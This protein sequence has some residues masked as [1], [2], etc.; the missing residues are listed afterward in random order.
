[1]VSRLTKFNK[2][3]L[4]KAFDQLL[5]PRTPQEMFMSRKLSF[6]QKGET[7]FEYEIPRIPTSI[8]EGAEFH[9]TTED[10]KVKDDL[11]TSLDRVG[12]LSLVTEYSPASATEIIASGTLENIGRSMKTVD[13]GWTDWF[14]EVLH[15]EGDVVYLIPDTNLIS[16]HYCSNVLLPLLG[17]E[18]F[19]QLKFR[20]PRLVVLEVESRCNRSK[21]GTK[22]KRL[23]FYAAKEILFLKR[24]HA[25]LLPQLNIS[26]LEG[27]SRI[28]GSQPR[29]TDAW[30]RR[31]IHDFM[32][33]E[34]KRRRQISVEG[35]RD[36]SFGVIFL[37]CD[38]MNALAASAEDIP[39]L[40]FS[41]IR[42]GKIS[43]RDHSQLVELIIDTAI[44]FG[45]IKMKLTQANKHKVS[46]LIKGIW[47]PKTPIDWETD[48]VEIMEIENED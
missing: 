3:K 26:L 42:N 43:F 23:A 5:T 34:I 40:Y 29:F 12:A 33:E 2:A 44:T 31:E 14:M 4:S 27:F 10:E 35:A 32:R 20:L 47:S 37:T 1:M 24:Y 22:D 8:A 19:R 7:L 25:V 28:A 16:R 45:E 39:T 15:I 48:S 17:E 21:H 36:L 9:I 38:L 18:R 13:E 11:L 41:R 46:L 6:T 30:I